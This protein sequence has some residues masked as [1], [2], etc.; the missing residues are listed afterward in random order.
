MWENESKVLTSDG[1][2]DVFDRVRIKGSPRSLRFGHGSSCLEF[3]D[4]HK[5]RREQTQEIKEFFIF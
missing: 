5:A 2:V 4:M 3:R 1:F